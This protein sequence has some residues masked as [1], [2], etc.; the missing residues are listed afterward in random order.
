[1]KRVVSSCSP[2]WFVAVLILI[3]IFLLVSRPD[4]SVE[5]S[6]ID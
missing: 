1:M 6:M 3:F 4:Y 2:G 5:P